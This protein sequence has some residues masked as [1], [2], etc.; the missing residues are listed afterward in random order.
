MILRC[1]LKPLL[2]QIGLLSTRCPRGEFLL[3]SVQPV[4]YASHQTSSPYCSGQLATTGFAWLGWSAAMTGI[5]PWFRN[6]TV[7]LILSITCLIVQGSEV[8]LA[9]E[10]AEL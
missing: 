9:E 10:V 3:V 5:W 8:D 7:S 4:Q 6:A 2:L 1:Q